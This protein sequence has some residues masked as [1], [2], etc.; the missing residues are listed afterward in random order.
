MSIYDMVAKQFAIFY[1]HKFYPLT[2]N[3]GMTMQ[4][5]AQ[6]L[7]QMISAETIMLTTAFTKQGQGA[8]QH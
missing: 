7:M 3:L 5:V 8:S 2:V 1:I 4:L 6:S